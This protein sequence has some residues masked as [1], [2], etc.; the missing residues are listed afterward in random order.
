MKALNWL[1]T[2]Y[3]WRWSYSETLYIINCNLFCPCQFNTEKCKYA[4]KH[5]LVI[6]KI[7]LLFLAQVK[8]INVQMYSKKIQGSGLKY[9]N[10]LYY[11]KALMS[12]K[13]SSRP[14][15]KRAAVWFSTCIHHKVRRIINS[16]QCVKSVLECSVLQRRDP[17]GL[18]T[19][20]CTTGWTSMQGHSALIMAAPLCRGFSP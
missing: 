10:I 7:Q 9:Y 18:L 13:T 17:T 5:A 16:A 2:W 3:D 8:S 1:C 15:L 19:V 11:I 14:I 6:I 4:F 12:P 20:P